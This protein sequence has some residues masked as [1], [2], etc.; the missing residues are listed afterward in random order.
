MQG[1]PDSAGATRPVRFMAGHP[2]RDMLTEIV[3]MPEQLSTRI[4][5]MM[6]ANGDEPFLA[7]NSNDIPIEQWR[8]VPGFIEDR[9][10]RG[11]LG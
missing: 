7:V 6:P 3:S 8:K 2:T 1:F 4:A 10:R 9:S 11:M 5:W